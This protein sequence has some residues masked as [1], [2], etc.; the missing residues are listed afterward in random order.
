VVLGGQGAADKILDLVVRRPQ[1]PSGAAGEIK[2]AFWAVT[3]LIGTLK[4]TS[5][6]VDWV[7]TLVP[8]GE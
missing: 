6:R 2:K 1:K 4:V 8:V 7:V 5:M 3:L